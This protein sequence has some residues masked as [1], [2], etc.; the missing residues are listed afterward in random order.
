MTTKTVKVDPLSV[1]E[2]LLMEAAKVLRDGGLLILPTDTVYGLAANAADKEAVRRLYEI[3]GRDKQ[4]PFAV[5]IRG[6]EQA[7]ELAGDISVGAYKLMD[8][9]WPGPLTLVLRSKEGS[10][11]GLRVPGHEVALKVL[12]LAGVNA[13]CPSANLSGKTAPLDFK[14]AIRDFDGVVDL[15]IDAGEASLKKESTVVDLTGQKARILREGGL[16]AREIESALARKAVLFICTGNSCRSVMAQAYLQKKL[17]EKG[18]D[19]VEV[20]SA[21]ILGLY[22][23]TA[24][25]ETKEVL[26]REG[27][28]VDGHLS[29]KVTPAMVKRS[30]LILVMEKMHEERI[31]EIA[32]QARNRV[33][34]LKEF[35]RIEDSGS[36]AIEDPIGNSV[37]FYE[38]TFYIIKEAVNRVAEII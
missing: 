11:I 4:K 10:T 22:N 35:A 24:S 3:K 21:G 19:D 16:S 30:D 5:L 36:T 8:R 1:R 6:S 12:E 26:R 37:D 15:A 27:I 17:K 18:R 9:F 13:A 29:T 2:E 14:E 7:E 25:P 38:R 31:I 28:N 34:L 23:A 20:L 33:F 32:P